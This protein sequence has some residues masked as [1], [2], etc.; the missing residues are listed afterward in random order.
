MPVIFGFA[1]LAAPA[2]NE[3]TSKIATAVT[4]GTAMTAN[5]RDERP[6]TLLVPRPDA[7]HDISRSAPTHC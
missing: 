2:K 5:E 7:A 6:A 1:A 4:L 3:A